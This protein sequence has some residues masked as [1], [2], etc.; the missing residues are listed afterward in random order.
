[1]IS[2]DAPQGSP[3]WRQIR[4]DD[5]DDATTRAMTGTTTADALQIGCPDQCA[6]NLSI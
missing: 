6:R 1:V 4:D 5:S 3:Q 2:G